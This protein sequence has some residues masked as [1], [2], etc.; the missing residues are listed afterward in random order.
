MFNCDRIPDTILT[1]EKV[2]NSLIYVW[3]TF[4]YRQLHELQTVKKM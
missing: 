4:L 1:L 3:I 2:L